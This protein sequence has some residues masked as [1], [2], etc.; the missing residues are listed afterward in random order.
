MS[1]RL[2]SVVVA[3]GGQGPEPGAGVCPVTEP[4]PESGEKQSGHQWPVGVN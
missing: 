3:G 2:V 4:E 1:D